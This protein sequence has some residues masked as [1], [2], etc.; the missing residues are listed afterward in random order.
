MIWLVPSVVASF[1]GG[2]VEDPTG[3]ADKNK[4]VMH[5]PDERQTQR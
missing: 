3:P 2:G 5:S 4:A 1:A